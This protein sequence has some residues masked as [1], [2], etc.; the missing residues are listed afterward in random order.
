MGSM[1]RTVAQSAETKR[2]SLLTSMNYG[3]MI[4]SI[5]PLDVVNGRYVLNKPLT[6]PLSDIL[7]FIICSMKKGTKLMKACFRIL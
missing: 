1:D 6:E 4:Q 2:M 3:N 7:F 5:I